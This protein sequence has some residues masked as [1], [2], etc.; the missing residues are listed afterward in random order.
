[1]TK[2]LG[3]YKCIDLCR[4]GKCRFLLLTHRVDSLTAHTPLIK[5]VEVHPLIK[6][7]K[8]QKKAMKQAVLD[9]P[10]PLN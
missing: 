7:V 5:G 4:D 10:Y 1:M 2:S 8:S 6:G 9:S 3:N